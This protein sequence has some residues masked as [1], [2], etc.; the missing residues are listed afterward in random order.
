MPID[1]D[2]DEVEEEEEDYE[3]ERPLSRSSNDFS[4]PEGIEN[5][6]PR[7]S[8]DSQNLLVES[9]TSPELTPLYVPPSPSSVAALSQ[10][11]SVT[12]VSDTSASP[13]MFPTRLS[14]AS[15]VGERSPLNAEFTDVDDRQIA[16]DF[17]GK[18]NG[19]S[20]STTTWEKV[21]KTFTRSNS[22]NGRRSRT[23]SIVTR[24][25]RD[26]TDSSVSR[27]SGV[28]LNSAK[29]DKA[30]TTSTFA[31]Q[32]NQQPLMQS[33]SASVSYV[34]LA[35]TPA[36]RGGVS[37]VPPPLTSDLGSKYQSE[38]L[39]PFPG[40]KKLE[41]Q[42]NRAKGLLPTS[43]SN[44][45]VSAL[46]YNEEEQL[47]PSTTSFNM[48]QSSY[49]GRDRSIPHQTSD[50]GLMA[51][52]N[53]GSPLSQ[54]SSPLP[55]QP[56]YF[57]IVP[58]PT[59]IQNSGTSSIKLP[60]TLTG[61]KQWLTN[62]KKQ[63]GPTF[64][65]I[66]APVEIRHEQNAFKKP[67][68]SDLLKKKEG[69]LTAEWEE[70][71]ST[72][73]SASGSTVVGKHI[74]PEVKEIERNSVSPTQAN[75][76]AE[77]NDVD[78]TPRKRGPVPFD[79]PEFSPPPISSPA[80]IPSPPDPVSSTTPDPSSS[81]SDYP[82]HSTSESSSS[83]SSNYSSGGNQGSVV[84]ERLD[85]TLARGSRSPM[86]AAAIENTPRKFS[87]STPVL[88]V[89]NSNTVKDRFLFLFNDIL[90]I[91]KPLLQ[92]ED[93]IHTKIT[94]DE[95][96]FTVKSVVQLR[97]LRFSA[98]R[99]EPA[100]KSPVSR[101][102]LIRTFIHQFTKNPD[103]AISTLLSKSN[104]PDDPVF[105][106]QVLFKTIELDRV[107]LGTY[108][109]RRTSKLVL[110][111][112]VDSF[113]FVG[114][115]V[116]KA[117]R[118]FLLSM[119]IP[120]TTTPYSAL[121]YLLDSFAGRWYEANAGIVA[122]D[123]DLAVRLV[124]ALVQLNELLHGAIAQEPGPTPYPRRN[125]NC[126]DFVEA[127]RR[128]DVRNLVPDDVLEEAYDSVRYERLCQARIPS[129]VA[130]PDL[131]IIIKRSLPSRVIYK[132]QSEPISLRIP[133][134][135]P[136][137]CIQLYGQDLVFDP[138]VLT[139]QRSSEASFRVTGTSLGV[140]TMIMCRSGP[141]ALKYSGLPLSNLL[142]VERAF[143]RN[144]FQIA[145]SNHTGAKRRYMFS[146][147]DSVK[148][149]FWVQSLK[150]GIDS[151]VASAASPV[152]S[153]SGG[154]SK[155]HRAMEIMAFRTLQ[156][157]LMG[158]NGPT[159]VIEKAL[160]QLNHSPRHRSTSRFPP[161]QPSGNGVVSNGTR[162]AP[163]HV[164]SKSRSQVYHRQAGKNELD[165]L[166]SAINGKEESSDAYDT[167]QSTRP[168][169]PV[170]T[171]REL[172]LQCL[173]NSSIALVLSFLQVGAPDHGQLPGS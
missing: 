47:S 48:Q 96:K 121:E 114:L 127:F 2:E 72:P 87:T 82:A 163:L 63:P 132:A 116:D 3:D 103:H 22:S 79:D 25:R 59:S 119:H 157:S 80:T 98:S 34:S 64:P 94:T 4:P 149:H 8:S 167:S 134:P 12:H 90:V 122:Y 53:I 21:R 141:N 19:D 140:K 57:N 137:L 16:S 115:R 23:N 30:E 148:C 152:T 170:W 117:L 18:R 150:Q 92:D 135:D 76:T 36:S 10:T 43:L 131:P 107:Q 133:H 62:S 9:E 37:P 73:T 89:V 58:S 32:Q 118:V 84:I 66:S 27:E 35:P 95:R 130:S 143:M 55:S 173:Q 88:Q 108:L 5:P 15:P 49:M 69:E 83:T 13:Q 77:Y 33:Q 7:D 147:D 128:Y 105:L 154:T 106:G 28:S 126:R 102:P 153:T 160:H 151:C 45:D 67:S 158:T 6:S 109:A 60:M 71:G 86:W 139:F 155:F 129:S 113:A 120:T 24:E 46:A 100:S 111:S 20:I 124:R 169:V 68:L 161:E 165:L 65:T 56:E 172:Q 29:T 14:V 51:K 52:Y 17:S 166:N 97:H 85:E 31:T 138:P 40:I 61:V 145:F 104:S 78:R 91:A 44:P 146:I 42:R 125:I 171:G 144:T 11:A 1:D 168:D 162:L 75:F 159:T 93:S 164:R 38:K 81:L 136:H 54:P 50:S 39:Q 41:E 142:T 110:K 70:L 26:H 123:K 156:E 99:L 101:N 74:H 112:Y